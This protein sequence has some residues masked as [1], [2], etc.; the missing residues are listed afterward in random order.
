MGLFS[1]NRNHGNDTYA[2]QN[3][4]NRHGYGNTGSQFGSHANNVNN[5]PPSFSS[6]DHGDTYGDNNVSHSATGGYRTLGHDR[7][8][9]LTNQENTINATGDHGILHHDGPT[10]L[11]GY[12]TNITANQGHFH[13]NDGGALGQDANVNT[14]GRHGVSRHDRN[15][16][17]VDPNTDM[18]AHDNHTGQNLVRDYNEPSVASKAGTARRGWFNRYRNRDYD[19]PASS[20][21]TTGAAVGGG[22]LSRNRRTGVL[23]LHRR[24]KSLFTGHQREKFD[25]NS[26]LYNRRASF[27]EWLAYGPLFYHRQ[28][29]LTRLRF[30]WLDILT[31]V[32]LSA[33]A[34][35]VNKAGPAPNRSFSVFFQDGQVVYPQ[36]AYP[37]RDEIIPLWLSAFLAVIIPISIILCMQLRIRECIAFVLS[38]LG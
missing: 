23:K 31:M 13:R 36:F 27:G 22:W 11:P 3:N 34:L 1:S 9:G 35:G 18:N 33:I 28:T 24:S 30:T 5:G 4:A 16:T 12:N 8:A 20:Q 17:L 21:M 38:C 26:G 7:N 25:V 37:V 19:G 14:D 29:V 10:R 32:I 6:Y 2:E 15:V